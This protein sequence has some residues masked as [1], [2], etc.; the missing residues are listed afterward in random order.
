MII[1]MRDCE[2]LSVT[3]MHVLYT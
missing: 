1:T 3:Y 2:K